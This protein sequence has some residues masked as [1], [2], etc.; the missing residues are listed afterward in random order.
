MPRGTVTH[1]MTKTPE[2]RAWASMIQRCENPNSVRYERYG[3][4]GIRVCDRWRDFARFIEDMGLRPSPDHS[5][6]R[7]DNDGNYEPTNCRWATRS[8]QQRNKGGYR[9]DHRLPRGQDH[10]TKRDPDR[11]ASVA[12]RNIIKSHN[13]GSANNKAKLTEQQV[14]AIKRQIADGEPDTQI[15][16]SFGVRPGAIWFIRSGKNWSHV[17]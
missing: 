13:R 6:D 12:R 1:G 11:A 14:R 16:A 15:A 4:R 17:E 5:I 2:Y 8:E 3:A 9:P 10:W 7:I